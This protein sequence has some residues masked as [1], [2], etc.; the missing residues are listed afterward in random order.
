[1]LLELENVFET[2]NEETARLHFEGALLKLAPISH[3]TAILLKSLYIESR[4]EQST[5]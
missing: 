5:C 3:K 4:I 2:S 1:M